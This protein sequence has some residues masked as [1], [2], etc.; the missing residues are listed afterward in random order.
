[1]KLESFWKSKDTVN[2]GHIDNL[3]IGKKKSSQTRQLIS[4]IYKELKKLTSKKRSVELNREF[5]TSR[6]AKR[7]LKKCSE[8]LVTREMQI[9][10]SLRSHLRPI[11]MAKIKTQVIVHVGENVEKE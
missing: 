7:H 8:S 2:S 4:K 1:M 5:P 9:K 11:R 10:T 6:I 3:Q